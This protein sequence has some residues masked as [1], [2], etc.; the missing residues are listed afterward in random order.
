MIYLC[1]VLLKYTCIY[2]GTCQNL[3][4][5]MAQNAS[6]GIQIIL[7]STK[8]TNSSPVNIT[9][10]DHY[11]PPECG[12]NHLCGV[13]HFEQN[14]TDGEISFYIIPSIG[15]FVMLAIIEEEPQN[16]FVG[17]TE[18][19]NP[20]RAFLAEDNHIIIACMDLQARPRLY[21]LNY[22]FLPNS[23][24]SGSIVRATELP[25]RSEMIF[26]TT[27]SEIIHVRGQARC[28]QS[29]NLYIIDDAYI[30]RFPVSDTF[31]PEFRMS[32]PLQNC[33]GYQSFEYYGNDI[34]IIRCA[35]NQ[36]ALYDSCT[37]HFTY[38]PPDRVPYPCT[39]WSSTIAYRN[40]Q[41]TLNRD[42]EYAA[43]QLPFSDLSYGKCVQG[44]DHPTFIAS[45]AD[46]SIFIAPFDGSNFTKITS[47]N[48]SDNDMACP[49]RPVFSE[50]E[51]VFGVL[52][53][54]TG[55]LVIVNLTEGCNNLIIASIPIPFMPSL[56]SISLGQGTYN[57]NC[58]LATVQTV[59]P[60]STTQ[61]PE[62]TQVEPI[63][64]TTRMEF[65]TMDAKQT[66]SMTAT[67]VGVPVSLFVVALLII[68]IIM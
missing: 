53:S 51:K 16:S 9:I 13:L 23:T 20:T 41:L 30:L 62:A 39:N 49:R 11:L 55:S 29:D 46:G 47:G 14:K 45:S 61:A 31:D 50:N 2:V 64:P 58:S 28:P 25:T 43:Q 44:V 3:D 7:A 33:V 15:G 38:P 54:T 27:V 68:M 34:L 32:G 66:E 17:V 48:C 8:T 60:P 63:A 18:E 4:I 6:T 42:G 10:A 59:E 52:D 37:G 65:T 22:N 36:T 21:Y 67:I 57:C 35:N 12:V 19:C 26:N 1:H 56:T 24:G 5:L 40:R